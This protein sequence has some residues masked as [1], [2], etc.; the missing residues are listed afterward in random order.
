[1]VGFRELKYKYTNREFCCNIIQ[2]QKMQIIYRNQL[3]ENQRRDQ[4]TDTGIRAA[5]NTSIAERLDYAF[6]HKRAMKAMTA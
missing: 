6:R 4:L 1:M 5:G 2:L 3:R